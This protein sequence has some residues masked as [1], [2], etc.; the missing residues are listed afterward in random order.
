VSISY[1]IYEEKLREGVEVRKVRLGADGRA[2]RPVGPTYAATPSREEFLILI[3]MIANE[4]WD[5]V[6][7]DE[8]RAFIGAVHTVPKEVL[9]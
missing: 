9:V 6:H 1:S 8:C 7:V 4:D 5:W 2:H 3:H